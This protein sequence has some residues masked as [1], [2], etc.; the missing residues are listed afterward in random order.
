MQSGSARHRNASTG[1]LFRF[2][3]SYEAV[4]GGRIEEALM[5][6]T[7]G[8][9]EIIQVSA[10]R[11]REH[12]FHETLKLILWQAHQQKSLL[13][14]SISVGQLPLQTTTNT[15][16][17]PFCFSRRAA[18]PKGDLR[19]GSSKAMPTASRVSPTSTPPTGT[20]PSSA[21]SVS[22]LS[23]SMIGRSFLNKLLRRSVGQP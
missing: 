12:N 17:L 21:V 22:R 11:S 15:T 7:G 8:M 16:D 6:M 2:C 23:R 1:R 9:G 18:S 3:G 10:R 14:C 19:M 13:G 4:I 5:H 20:R